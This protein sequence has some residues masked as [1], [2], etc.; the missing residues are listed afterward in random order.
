MIVFARHI[1][2]VYAREFTLRVTNGVTLWGY[3]VGSMGGVYGWG[4]LMG[5]TYGVTL[6]GLLVGSN[7]HKERCNLIGYTLRGFCSHYE[8]G[9]WVGF[10]LIL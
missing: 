2:G 4:L 3:L 8:R 10:L 1:A 6:W 5:F 7:G 9:L